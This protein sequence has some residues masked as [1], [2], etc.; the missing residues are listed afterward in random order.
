MHVSWVSSAWERRTKDTFW[1]FRTIYLNCL[2]HTSMQCVFIAPCVYSHI[3]YKS[4]LKTITVFRWVGSWL[5]WLKTY[6]APP[7]PKRNNK[8]PPF[9]TARITDWKLNWTSC[10]GLLKKHPHRHEFTDRHYVATF[11]LFGENS[12]ITQDE[13][14]RN[15]TGKLGGECWMQKP[16]NSWFLK[17]LKQHVIFAKGSLTQ[18]LYA[19]YHT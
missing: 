6:C 2:H 15:Q 11:C 18:L 14:T 5:H 7:P 10:R 17:W 4:C 1:P 13:D 19:V 3:V 9:I 12:I 8:L 16:W